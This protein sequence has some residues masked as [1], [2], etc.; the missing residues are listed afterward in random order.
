MKRSFVRVWLGLFGVTVLLFAWSVLVGTIMYGVP[1]PSPVVT[2]ETQVQPTAVPMALISQSF[3]F[4]EKG[5]LLQERYYEPVIVSISDFLPVKVSPVMGEA[6]TQKFGAHRKIFT[7]M[8][9]EITA[10][11][12]LQKVDENARLILQLA[13]RYVEVRLK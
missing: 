4:D 2:E 6:L 10:G 8:V 13:D 5:K 7:D 9:S 1:S 3:Y 11:T 12:D